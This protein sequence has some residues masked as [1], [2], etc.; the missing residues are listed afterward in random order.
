MK[1][2]LIIFILLFILTGCNNYI[3]NK[4]PEYTEGSIVLNSENKIHV[5]N[6][7]FEE[8]NNY[9]EYLKTITYYV[10]DESKPYNF[11][12]GVNYI[13]LLYID[14]NSNDYNGY[15]VSIEM[16]NSKPE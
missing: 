1:K 5:D 12:N 2:I 7:S 6:T 14:T 15:N 10:Y 8:F 16:Y 11:T 4:I 13:T 9:I 3:D